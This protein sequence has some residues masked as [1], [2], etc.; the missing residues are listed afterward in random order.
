MQIVYH[1]SDET[2]GDTPAVACLD[3][4]AWA[5]RELCARFPHAVV[6]VDD[7]PSLDQCWTDDEARREEIQDFCARLWDLCPWDWL[8]FEDL[9]V[10]LEEENSFFPGNP[11]DY[12]DST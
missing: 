10:D 3:Y 6:V 5:H 1:A 9:P 2:M 11:A 7:A 8:E 12:G 4:R